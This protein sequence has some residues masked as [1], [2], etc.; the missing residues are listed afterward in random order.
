MATWDR[1]NPEL[2]HHVQN[3]SSADEFMRTT[4]TDEVYDVYVARVHLAHCL[5]PFGP[6]VRLQ[7]R[8]HILATHVGCSWL[9]FVQV[10]ACILCTIAS[11]T[12]CGIR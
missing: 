10:S 3:D 8:Q 7:L 9:G 1:L 4:F 12:W 2:I 6:P 11:V 5:K